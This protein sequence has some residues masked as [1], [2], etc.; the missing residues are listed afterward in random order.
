MDVHHSRIINSKLVPVASFL[1]V[2]DVTELE[3]K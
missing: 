3:H 1:T 2:T